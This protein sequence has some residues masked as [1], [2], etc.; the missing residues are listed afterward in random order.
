MSNPFNTLEKAL[1]DAMSNSDKIADFYEI[2]GKSTIWLIKKQT[3]ELNADRQDEFSLKQV[4][5]MEKKTR[6]L[7]PVFSS[8]FPIE[9]MFKNSTA[10]AVSFQEVLNQIDGQTGIILNPDTPL[11]KLLIPQELDMMKKKQNFFKG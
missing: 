8:K 3:S 11:S 7:L 4:Q 9:K 10:I 2:L 1:I 5:I 6:K